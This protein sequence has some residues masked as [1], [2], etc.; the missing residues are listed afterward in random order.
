MIKKEPND[1]LWIM[2]IKA[3][4][5]CKKEEALNC[6]SLVLEMISVDVMNLQEMVDAKKRTPSGEDT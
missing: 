1:N 6:V 2:H 3:N 5:L 4:G